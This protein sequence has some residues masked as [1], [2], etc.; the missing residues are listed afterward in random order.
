MPL[1]RI[2]NVGTIDYV[3]G[4]KKTIG[5][6]RDGVALQY[7]LRLQFTCT[8][9]AGGPTGPLFQTLARLIRHV[10]VI[11]GGRDTVVSASGEML[12]A[13]AQYEWG[14]PADGMD[15]TVVLTNSAVTVYD[16]TIPI[17]RA[18]PRGQQPLLTADDLRRVSQAVLEITWGSVADLFTADNGAVLSALTCWLEVEYLLDVAGDVTFGVREL[19]EITQGY[20]SSNDQMAVVIDGQTGN[21][22]RSVAVASLVA[23]VGSNTPLNL[24]G[25]RIES[26]SFVFRNRKGPSIQAHNRSMFEQQA[27]IVGFYYMPFEWAGDPSHAI[28]TRVGIL[29]TDLHAVFDI[30]FTAGVHELKLSIESIRPLRIG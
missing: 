3:S 6:P 27:P 16:V 18:L 10:D 11:L 13:R 22:V 8:N 12:A 5:L 15:D 20:T 28:D 4:Q 24:G 1:P 19:R 23:G 30:A 29:P 7:N 2:V 21:R 14:V 26:G 17:P 25:V 9:A